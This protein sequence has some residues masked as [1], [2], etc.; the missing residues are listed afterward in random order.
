[1]SE[2]RQVTV[3][4]KRPKGSFP[5]QVCIGYYTVIDGVVTMT[6]R[7]GKPAGEETGRRY[8]HKLQPNESANAVA[9]R[10]TRELRNALRGT[11]QPVNGFSGPIRY[12]P[13]KSIV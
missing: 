4:I 1:M 11:S 5:G 7:H 3:E 6:D 9:C 8:V 12:R 2:V 13:D 10:M